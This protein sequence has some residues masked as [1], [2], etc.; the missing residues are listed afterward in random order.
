VLF[1]LRQ[2]LNAGENTSDSIRN[3]YVE[4]GIRLETSTPH[5]PWQNGRVE[6]HIN[7]ISNFAHTVMNSSGLKGSFW[8]RAYSYAND[9]SNVQPGA[10]MNATPYEVILWTQTQLDTLSTIWY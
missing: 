4:M 10:S 3:W 8:A 5:E 9:A 1:A 7:H 2:S 6:S